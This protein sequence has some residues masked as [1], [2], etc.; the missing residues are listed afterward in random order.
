MRVVLHHHTMGIKARAV[1]FF[2]EPLPGFLY[3]QGGTVQEVLDTPLVGRDYSV[4]I[5]SREAGVSAP[6]R[7]LR[8][9]DLSLVEAS[10]IIRLHGFTGPLEEQH[11][12]ALSDRAIEELGSEVGSAWSSTFVDV[13]CKPGVTDA[14]GEMAALALRHAGLPDVRCEAGS[15][16]RFAG[17]VSP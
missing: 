1:G 10:R 13:F 6:A 4:E 14:E 11:L 16:Y 7:E 5:R 8:Q 17:E 15:R 12:A 9:L 2:V 3:F